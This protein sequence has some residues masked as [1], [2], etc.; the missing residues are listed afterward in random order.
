MLTAL[1]SENATRDIKKIRVKEIFINS[2]VPCE[3]NK[4]RLV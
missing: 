1:H 2:S 4:L 3:K